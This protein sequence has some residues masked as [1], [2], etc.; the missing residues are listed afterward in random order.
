MK[1]L[2]DPYR[3]L[4]DETLDRYPTLRATRLYDM[5]RERGFQGSVRTLREHVALVRP[6]SRREVYLRTEPLIGE[7]SQVDWAYVSKTDVPGGQRD[8]WLFV[9]VKGRSGD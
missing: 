8:L 2:V 9:I 5:L 7:Q 1:R 3:E 6:R 4:I